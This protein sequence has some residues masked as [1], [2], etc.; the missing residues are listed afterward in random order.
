[1]RPV[2]VLV[3]E[4]Q[5]KEIFAPA[6]TIICLDRDAAEIAAQRSDNVPATF[7]GG[8]QLSYVSYTSGSTGTPKGV[9]VSHRGVVRL[10]RGSNYGSFA[11][12]NVYLQQAP[13]SF[14]ASTWELFAPLLNGGR[15]VVLREQILSAVELRDAI[16]RYQINSLWLTTSMFNAVVD[17]EVTVLAALQQVLLGGEVASV[18]HI[19]HAVEQLPQTQLIN[20]YGPTE[21]TTFTSCYPIGK[22]LGATAS[23]IPI[24]PPIANTHVYIL[25]QEMQPVPIGVA[26]ELYIGGDGL[27]RG[28]VSRPELTAE[29][30]VPDPFSKKGGERLYRTGDLTRWLAG[31]E[32]EFIGRRDRQVKLRGFRIELGEVEA[33]LKRIPQVREAV[34][35]LNGKHSN[36]SLA[37]YVVGDGLTEAEIRGSLQRQLPAYMLPGQVLV[38]ERLPLKGQGKVNLEELRSLAESMERD[39][40]GGP[41]VTVAE[42]TVAEIW[43]A[44]LNLKNLG[45]DANFFALGGHSLI[46]TQVMVR[47]QKA[48]GVDLPLRA[49]FENPTV[50]EFAAQIEAALQE[51]AASPAPPLVPVA[52]DGEFP[53]SFAQ[54]RLWFLDQLEPGQ[55]TYNVPA[56]MRVT[57][58]LNLLALHQCLTEIVRRHEALRTAFAGVDGRPVATLTQASELRL[59]V[60]DLQQLEP[61]RR[62][63]EVLRLARAEADRPFDLGQPPLLRVTLLRLGQQEQVVLFT[64]HHITCDAWSIAQLMKEVTRL[65]EAYSRGNPSPL[66]DLAIQYGDYAVWQ[67]QWLQGEVLDEKLTAWERQFGD[68]PPVVE[69][70]ADTECNAGMP[71]RAARQ[72]LVLS[73]ELT[74]EL[75]ALGQRESATMFMTMLAAFECVLH[76]YSGQ[77]DMVVG[78]GIANRNRREIEEL[79]GLFVNMLV[80]R[81]DLSGNPTFKQLLARVRRTT[82]AA[83]ALEDLPFEKLVEAIQPERNVAGTALLKLTFWHQSVS[84]TSLSLEGLTFTPLELNNDSIYF[85]LMVELV[86][87]DEGFTI[88]LSY[89]TNQFKPETIARLLTDYEVLL[90]SVVEQP[91]SRLLDIPILIQREKYAEGVR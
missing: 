68:N 26:G 40:E 82:L 62:E 36:A 70:P 75:K 34:V 86:E 14:D 91:E 85:D 63:P 16:E 45:R 79:I 46:A 25:D 3:T 13:I 35:D 12:T 15:C 6:S 72:K 69:L 84:L 53:L 29:K 78:T 66:R 21:N 20:C 30:F 5:L 89:D 47:V 11:E 39:D 23:S 59:R 57:G 43:G 80:V 50:S 18:P 81:T 17:E 27:A 8:D 56:A 76:R 28:Y 24:G 73:Q 42:Q 77:V 58:N 48:T 65:Y 74:Q 49:L 88:R 7:H 52:R 67:R 33:A 64:M 2:K 71:A 10:V 22:E 54:Q 19:L 61:D 60:I 55:A 1:M 44:L 87:A 32:I 90:R 4:E 41:P 31:G 9:A 83:F 51:G 38:L 37:A